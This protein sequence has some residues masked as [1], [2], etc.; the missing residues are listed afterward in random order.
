M[1]LTRMTQLP[2]MVVAKNDDQSNKADW[3]TFKDSLRAPIHSWFTYP[4]GFSYK[5]VESS[6]RSNQIDRGNFVYDPFM[7]SGTTNLTAKILGMNSYGVEAHPFVFKI[8]RAKLNWQISRSAI[9]DALNTIEE[10]VRQQ[11][12][13]LEQNTDGVL[14]A[15]FP[16]LVLKCFDAHI[17]LDLLFIRK[18]IVDQ[19]F[20]AGLQDFLMVGL[21]GLLRQISAVETGW[22]Y[23]A[24]KKKKTSSLEKNALVEYSRMLSKM[25]ADIEKTVIEA[26]PH[27]AQTHHHIFNADSRNTNDLIPDAC[28]DHV[29]TSPPYLNNFDYAD[30]TRLEMYF[31][32]EAKTWDDITQNVRSRLITSATTQI[33]RNDSRYILSENLSR[34]CPEIYDFL[35]KAVKRLSALRLTKGGKKSYD[36]LV[37]GYF[38][39]MYLILQDVFRVLKPGKRAI[40]VL[41]DSAP[42]G[43]HIPT[44][45]FV[46]KIGVGIGFSDYKIDVLRYRGGKWR[47]NPQRHNVELKESIV[48]LIKS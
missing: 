31:F 6:L 7:G 20:D 22:P 29:F 2:L 47:N 11:K 46:G 16:E 10:E 25:V 24:P 34:D 19:N 38:N 9:A 12:E 26:D 8:A 41:G 48:T 13:Q 5:A 4:A 23:I 14:E 3:G 44:D 37:S 21:T 28:V 42:Y 30:R 43:V 17:L 27:G 40:F 45:D 15:E 36:L 33:S 18:A 35:D 39:D 1:T 32:G